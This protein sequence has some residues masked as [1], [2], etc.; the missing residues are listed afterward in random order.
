MGSY[1]LLF[2]ITNYEKGLSIPQPLPALGITVILSGDLPKV[3]TESVPISAVSSH[4]L[5]LSLLS[6][7]LCTSA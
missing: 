2:H 4:F 3:S 7:M 5:L 1:D 6:V